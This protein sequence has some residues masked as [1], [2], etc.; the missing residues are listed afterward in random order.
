MSE[1][2]IEFKGQW[3]DYQARVLAAS[4]SHLKDG[5]IHIVASPGSGKTTLGL[6]LIGRLNQ[7]A[8]V[9]VPTVTIREQWVSR[10]QSSFVVETVDVSEFVSQDLKHPKKIT[11]A[12]YQA[13]HSAISHFKG[14]LKEKS[15]VNEESDDLLAEV[16]E[17]VDF[18]NFDLINNM[19]EL[20]LAT[21]CLDECHH[22]RNEWWKSLE[23]FC[24]SFP[25][26]KTIALTATPPYDS[27]P[28]LWQR[29]VK[30]CGEIDQEISI[31]E[32]VK[33]GS[34][35]PH[36][37]FVY[38]SQPS[39]E[40]KK[41]LDAFYQAS[42]QFCDSLLKSSSFQDAILTH[43][44]LS[45][46]LT[47]EEL[48]EHPAH[49]SS[50]L[51]YLQAKH[52]AYPPR[53]KDL[54]SD[55]KL[56]RLT[57]D[58][59]GQLLQYFCY[60]EAD[61][62][63]IEESYRKQLIK[64]M[65]ARGLIEKNKISLVKNQE[66][67]K[68]LLHSTGKIQSI[69]EIVSHEYQQSGRDLRQLI[70]TDYI[71]REFESQ[72]GQYQLLIQ[73]IGVLPIFEVLRREMVDKWQEMKMGILCGSIVVIPL[74]AKRAFLD[75]VDQEKVSLQNFAGL[76]DFI[77]V[78]TIG[79]SHFLTAAITELFMQGEIQ[80]L[81]GT[82]SL[83][84]EGWDAPCVNSLILASFVGSFMLSNQMRGRAIRS[85]GNHPE[86]TANIWHLIS[87][88]Q[89]PT[90]FVREKSDSGLQ[91]DLAESKPDDSMEQYGE[92][93]PDFQLLKRRTEHFLG[94]SYDGQTIESGME[95]LQTIKA[96]FSRK[97]L[98]EINL[99]MLEASS[100]RKAIR[101]GWQSALTISDSFEVA[102]LTEMPK[103]VVSS[104]LFID[105]K[106]SFIYSLL[107]AGLTLLL[108][109]LPILRINF[110]LDLVLILVLLTFIGIQ[111]WRFYHY[112]SPLTRL[113]V[114]GQ[115]LLHSL[116]DQN[117]LSTH[118]CKVHVETLDGIV[119]MISLKGGNNRDK[120]IFTQAMKE[121]FAPIDNQRYLIYQNGKKA[122]KEMAAYFAVP[123]IFTRQ[124]QI[125]D[126]VKKISH[127]IG[128]Y[129]LIYTRNEQGRKKLL[130]AR[131]VGLANQQN[132]L[133]NKK[134]VCK[135]D[136]K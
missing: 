123:S 51:I 31:P 40:E 99:S 84:G 100:N 46:Q 76:E 6:E 60:D 133:L 101:E 95:R 24:Q 81:I 21:V 15:D 97:K 23:F 36:Q 59:L 85:W 17:L 107:F 66:L 110:W 16:D 120:E 26:A 103:E 136:L 67:D 127:Y 89:R 52:Q 72:I 48:L 29:Y 12:T 9:L 131:V 86:K 102:S 92:D 30:M 45:G 126:F 58:W 27:T 79:S 80:V 63:G 38:F 77:S 119:M 115:G 98:K 83:L 78:S 28:A 87:M 64:E 10:I 1:T 49:L 108:H 128:Q 22:L 96:P 34:L 54:L 61:F 111:A 82:K 112:R 88:N 13:L 122:R 91:M 50:L 4:E 134:M 94:L 116:L 14:T 47:D 43:K 90:F 39:Q 106:R 121:F 44:A 11:V 65:K 41:K 57:V 53:L 104:A 42:F 135:S 125:L 117:K 129:E 69:K 62:Y 109:S 75:L 33:E 20:G 37:D 68:L 118:E 55:K 73:K 19:S 2:R 113:Q 35:C 71:R 7:T 124:D 25:K 56:P 70:L 18:S 32:L 3:R 114:F 105:A 130:E 5:K 93:S 8:L 132:Q 74:S